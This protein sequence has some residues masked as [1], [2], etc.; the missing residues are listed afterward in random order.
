MAYHVTSLGIVVLA[1]LRER[2]VHGHE[3]FQTL[4]AGHADRMLKVRPGSV[5][6]QKMRS[7]TLREFRQTSLRP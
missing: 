2:P 4:T 3:L 7:P 5:T 1:L 6:G